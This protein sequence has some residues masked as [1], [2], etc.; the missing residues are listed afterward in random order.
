[1]KGLVLAL[2]LTLAAVAWQA[3]PSAPSAES[4]P[5][6][7]AGIDGGGWNNSDCVQPDS[8]RLAGCEGD[9]LRPITVASIDGSD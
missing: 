1:M 7:T 2:T 9:E 8:D 3:V 5:A 6:I 4:G